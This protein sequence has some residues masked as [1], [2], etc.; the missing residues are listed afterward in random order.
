MEDSI[1][2][3]RALAKG[4]SVILST[5]A[6]A[7]ARHLYPAGYS[8]DVEILLDGAEESERAS[9]LTL[10]D[11]EPPDAGPDLGDV[12]A[13]QSDMGDNRAPSRRMEN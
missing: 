2:L 10:P 3:K 12:T 6:T 8:G 5:G 9:A 4:D 7:T 11:A 1:G 13:A